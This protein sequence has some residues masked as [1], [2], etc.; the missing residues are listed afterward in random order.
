MRAV[1][2]KKQVT[3][4]NLSNQHKTTN[5]MYKYM[6]KVM[7]IT[8][9]QKVVQCCSLQ[10]LQASSAPVPKNNGKLW[11]LK[12]YTFDMDSIKTNIYSRIIKITL[13]NV[14]KTSARS[15]C[16]RCWLLMK[17]KHHD[18]QNHT[19]FILYMYTEKGQESREHFGTAN[20]VKLTTFIR[21][22][23]KKR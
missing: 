14:N 1:L 13:I 16:A 15:C 4:L 6:W 12:I 8:K 21:Q 18:I 11:Q 2:Q 17:I 3:C 7:H 10:E 22:K 9:R 20:P 5:P 23:K 19:M